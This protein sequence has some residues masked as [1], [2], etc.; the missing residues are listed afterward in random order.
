MVIVCH[1]YKPDLFITMTYNPQWPEKN[2][3]LGETPQNRT[4]VVA[5]VYKLKMDKFLDEIIW[6]I[7]LII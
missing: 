6:R 5:R 1:F 2:I 3:K 4:H 7:I